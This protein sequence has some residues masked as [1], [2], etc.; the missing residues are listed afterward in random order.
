MS[1]SVSNSP[2]PGYSPAFN[3]GASNIP[4]IPIA[5]LT[6]LLMGLPTASA[7]E[8][9]YANCVQECKDEGGSA[10]KCG[11]LC[12]PALVAGLNF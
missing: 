9:A 5:I 3:V 12:A 6:I 4:S 1:M 7:D 2:F 11:L 10:L 8:Q